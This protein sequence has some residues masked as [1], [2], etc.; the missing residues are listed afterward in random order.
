MFGALQR[1]NRHQCAFPSL[2]HG[3]GRAESVS[4]RSRMISLAD[5]Y[6]AISSVSGACVAFSM[7]T[8][9]GLNESNMLDES[10]TDLDTEV[11]EMGLCHCM[12]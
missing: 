1:D 12:T 7:H 8:A 6:F 4:L 11:R 5:Y 10:E 2:G 9:Q 3:P